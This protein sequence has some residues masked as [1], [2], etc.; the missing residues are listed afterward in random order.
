MYPHSMHGFKMIENCKKSWLHKIHTLQCKN[1]PKMTYNAW[2]CLRWLSSKVCNSVKI[3]SSSIKKP[4]AH[5]QYVHNK[6]ARFQYDPLKTLRGVDY[7]NSIPYNAKCCLK[8]LS[9]ICCN[10]V[11]ISSSFIKN[12]HAHFQYLHNRYARFQKDPLKTVGG[13]D[14][15]NAIP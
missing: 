8:W 6:Y 1:L 12:P 11:K 3:N 7:Q 9:S 5:L 4:H 15:T 13:V 2:S 10:S 14:Y